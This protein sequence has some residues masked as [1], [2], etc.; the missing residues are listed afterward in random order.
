MVV[1]V[2]TTDLIAA[3]KVEAAAA[4]AEMA[5][6]IA[7]TDEE[8]VRLSVETSATLVLVD[9]GSAS[10]DVVSLVEQLRSHDEPPAVVAFGPHVHKTKLEAAQRAG[11]DQV[12]SRGGL[13]GHIDEILKEY[14]ELAGG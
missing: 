2:L 8:A 13:L 3:S 1:V 4:R 14:R 5:L 6:R 11:C 12:L 7:A 9:L 10:V